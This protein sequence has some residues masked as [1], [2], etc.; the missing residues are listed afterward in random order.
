MLKYVE[1]MLHS[2]PSVC[3]QLVRIGSV[4]HWNSKQLKVSNYDWKELAE[5]FTVLSDAEQRKSYD[6]DRIG[7][8]VAWTNVKHAEAFVEERHRQLL[9]NEW[10]G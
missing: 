10:I 7:Q 6:Q 1:I 4:L 8:R 5:A 9:K 2:S 3:V